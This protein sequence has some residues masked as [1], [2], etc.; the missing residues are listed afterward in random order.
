MSKIIHAILNSDEVYPIILLTQTVNSDFFVN[1]IL[2]FE[3]MGRKIFV[4][5]KQIL[6][7][8]LRKKISGFARQKKKKYSNT[9]G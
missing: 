1:A 9:C 6:N 4:F 3:E 2:I 8:K 5:L 7:V